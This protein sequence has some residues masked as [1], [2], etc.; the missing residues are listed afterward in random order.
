MLINDINATEELLISIPEY[1]L[2]I[3]SQ[4]NASTTLDIS[5]QVFAS[6]SALLRVDF[7]ATEH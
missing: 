1:P 3:D 2:H 5:N 6:H 4:H 7:M